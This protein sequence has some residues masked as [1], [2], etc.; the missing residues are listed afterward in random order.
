MRALRARV[1]DLAHLGGLDERGGRWIGLVL[2]LGKAGRPHDTRAE[3]PY[4]GRTRQ[5]GTNLLAQSRGA[6]AFGPRE[7]AHKED[8][9]NRAR[10]G[11]WW[12][13]AAYV[14]RREVSGV[15]RSAA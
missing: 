5:Q 13:S 12:Q 3:H 8:N 11:T 1:P 6:I 10:I 2:P 9:R 4:Q 15:D 14:R 7:S